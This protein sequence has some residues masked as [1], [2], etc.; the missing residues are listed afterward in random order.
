MAY[1]CVKGNTVEAPQA[2]VFALRRQP[3]AWTLLAQGAKHRRF[4]TESTHRGGC[5]TRDMSHGII[6][7]RNAGGGVIVTTVA[8]LQLK[9][10]GN[11]LTTCFHGAELRRRILRACHSLD[12]LQTTKIGRHAGDS[13]GVGNTHSEAGTGTNSMQSL[14]V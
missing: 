10:A 3:K 8:C 14:R 2:D 9:V 6:H 7:S 11:Q 5:H 13:A 4:L 12:E 1:P